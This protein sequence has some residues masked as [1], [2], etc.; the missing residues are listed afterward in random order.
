MWKITDTR[1]DGSWL[2]GKWDGFGGKVEAGETIAE[3]AA[4]FEALPFCPLDQHLRSGGHNFR[5]YVIR[6]L[7]SKNVN[8]TSIFL[9]RFFLMCEDVYIDSSVKTNLNWKHLPTK[10]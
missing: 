7:F 5:C 8:D 4:R 9:N 6:H 1:C 3:A 10:R 2:Q